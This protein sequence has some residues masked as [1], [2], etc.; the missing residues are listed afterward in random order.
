MTSV[1]TL[2]T[3]DDEIRRLLGAVK[4]IALVGASPKPWR[5]ASGIIAMLL[6]AGYD[7]IPVNPN[8]AEVLGATC[9]PDLVSIPTPVD[10]VNVFRRPSALEGLLA[11]VRQ[12]GSPPVWLQLGASDEDSARLAL[13]AGI[14]VVVER[15]IAVEYRRLMTT[16][17]PAVR[18]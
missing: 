2:I 14:S 1:P 6:G 7:V 15:C 17:N 16:P 18:R 5:D 8:Y 11:E 9:F 13:A 12:I 3:S 10:L 4:T